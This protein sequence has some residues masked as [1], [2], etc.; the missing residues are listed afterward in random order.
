ML[1]TDMA[2]TTDK[3]FRPW[4][5]KYA[6]DEQLFFSDFAKAFSTFVP[7]SPPLTSQH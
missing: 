4:A 3:A 6:K 5:E 7:V 2:L 1:R